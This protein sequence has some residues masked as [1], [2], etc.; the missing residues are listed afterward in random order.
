MR[1]R[2][3]VWCEAIALAAVGVTV[4]VVLAV[5]PSS[6][7]RP[8]AAGSRDVFRPVLPAAPVS[9]PVVRQVQVRPAIPGTSAM[10]ITWD[11]AFTALID[12]PDE[13]ALERGE[14][15]YDTRSEGGGT[16]AQTMGLIDATPEECFA[17]VRDY[18]HYSRTMP[19]TD[20]STVVRT[21]RLDGPIDPGAEAVDFWTR[22][23]V[24]GLKTR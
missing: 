17:V 20:E 6:P 21:F 22:V 9:G 5:R 8:L 12:A 23:N 14:V 18:E 19:F 1:R 15:L 2:R 16:V 3:L 24:G 4:A 11:D 13:A 7:S 10:P